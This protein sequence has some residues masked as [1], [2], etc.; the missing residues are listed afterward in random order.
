MIERERV[1]VLTKVASPIKYSR[2]LLPQFFLMLSANWRFA[3]AGG[4]DP[5]SELMF[6]SA[7][8]G[9]LSFSPCNFFIVKGDDFEVGCLDLL[10]L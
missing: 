7:V 2:S 3:S 1:Q 10:L 9:E 4:S 5:Q 8:V 6:H